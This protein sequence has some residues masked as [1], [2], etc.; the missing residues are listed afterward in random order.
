MPLRASS[1]KYA[2]WLPRYTLASHTKAHL[3]LPG[4]VRMREG[5]FPMRRGD[6][7]PRTW[8]VAELRS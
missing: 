5:Y 1:N 3:K 7:L 8:L 6:F 4:R 2:S